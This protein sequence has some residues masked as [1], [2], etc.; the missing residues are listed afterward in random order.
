MLVVHSV[1]CFLDTRGYPPKTAP[2]WASSS[3]TSDSGELAV[4]SASNSSRW[5]GPRRV[6]G[7]C[8]TTSHSNLLND[9][10][11]LSVTVTISYWIF[12]AVLRI[13]WA[14]ITT[15]FAQKFSWGSRGSG[16]LILAALL[17]VRFREKFLIRNSEYQIVFVVFPFR[18]TSYPKIIVYSRNYFGRLL[19]MFLMLTAA[20]ISSCYSSI[21]VSSVGYRVLFI[22]GILSH[23]LF[24]E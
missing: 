9:W 5:S 14:K 4:P 16:L 1:S 17:L 19:G 18:T 20:S 8:P 11:L 15:S 3:T 2:A 10:I 23:D 24:S 12:D 6:L 13:I 22:I 7:I 21:C